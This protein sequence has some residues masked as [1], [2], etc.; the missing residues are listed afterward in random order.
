MQ[1]RFGQ[2][3]PIMKKHVIGRA[4]TSPTSPNHVLAIMASVPSD[5]WTMASG[6]DSAQSAPSVLN[7]V[8]RSFQPINV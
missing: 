6:Q 3:I 2:D 5:A 4:C 7:D 1:G 8:I